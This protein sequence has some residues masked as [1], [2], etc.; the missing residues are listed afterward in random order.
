M[1]PLR[2]QRV[3]A[4]VSNGPEERHPR[5]KIGKRDV[6]GGA[7][8][9]RTGR[10]KLRNTV[11]SARGFKVTRLRTDVSRLYRIMLGE[12]ILHCPVIALSVGRLVVQS[13][14]AQCQSAIAH[15]LG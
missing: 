11:L 5:P 9:R 4:R 3:V 6:V 7:G 10:E 14:S 12:L 1:N 8:Q 15:V 13:D 2:L